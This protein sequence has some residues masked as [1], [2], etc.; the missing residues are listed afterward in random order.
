MKY[1]EK[2]IFSLW[3]ILFT[4][5]ILVIVPIKYAILILIFHWASLVPC[6]G[7]TL[8][9][10]LIYN[11]RI[12]CYSCIL[13]LY[14]K[15]YCDL[16]FK[17]VYMC[18][19]LNV[20]FSRLLKLSPNMSEVRTI[21]LQNIA[22]VRSFSICVLLWNRNQSQFFWTIFALLRT[23]N[24]FTNMNFFTNDGLFELFYDNE[25]CEDKSSFFHNE[26]KFFLHELIIVEK[27]KWWYTRQKITKKL[28]IAFKLLFLKLQ[29]VPPKIKTNKYV[30]VYDSFLILLTYIWLFQN[31]NVIIIEFFYMYF[32][33][34]IATYYDQWFYAIVNQY[35]FP[36]I[37]DKLCIY[38]I[39]DK[40]IL[41]KAFKIDKRF[42]KIQQIVNQFTKYRDIS[43]IIAGYEQEYLVDFDVQSSTIY[44]AY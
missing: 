21:F 12:N 33:S 34:L 36:K 37:L 16:D 19:F 6:G 4:F 29:Y 25:I 39:I 11:K 1:Y 8:E 38:E 42:C 28:D 35:Q 3:Q 43:F 30:I 41:Q 32:C 2:D 31:F 22:F 20:L 15:Y 27:K 24:Q 7:L 23:S 17:M 44:T 13:L 14:T 5:S 40:D 9:M 10:G 26:L 18:L